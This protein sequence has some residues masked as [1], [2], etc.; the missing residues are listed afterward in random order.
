M[1]L[2]TIIQPNLVILKII[3]YEF[4]W[5]DFVDILKLKQDSV[6]VRLVLQLEGYAYD[7]AMGILT[8]QTS[9]PVGVRRRE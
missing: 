5:F 1:S 4:I 7:G 8:R 3:V 6:I 9:E 2:D